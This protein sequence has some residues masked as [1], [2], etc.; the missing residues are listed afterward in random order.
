MTKCIV[1]RSSGPYTEAQAPLL[2]SMLAQQPEL[3][4]CVGPGCETWEDAIDWLCIRSDSP[5]ERGAFCMTSSHS[6]QGVKEA[7]A[8]AERWCDSRGWPREVSVV[9]I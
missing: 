1:L 2:R 7:I 5:D 6:R 8:F 4:A 3:F 9:E